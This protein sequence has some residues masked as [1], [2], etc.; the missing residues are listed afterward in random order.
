[1]EHEHVFFFLG[2]ENCNEETDHMV[3]NWKKKK[4]TREI[5]EHSRVSNI[6]GKGGLSVPCLTGRTGAKNVF[7]GLE[8]GMRTI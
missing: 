2:E 3:Y 8:H 4:N 5:Q 6:A 7:I 1:M